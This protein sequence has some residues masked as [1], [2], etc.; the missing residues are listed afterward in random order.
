[1][2]S[3]NVCLPQKSSEESGGFLSGM[4]RNA[5]PTYIL[6]RNLQIKVHVPLW[7]LLLLCDFCH[8]PGHERA[9]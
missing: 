7:S 5:S 4:P 2:V 3:F 9:R 6:A 8:L 1:M